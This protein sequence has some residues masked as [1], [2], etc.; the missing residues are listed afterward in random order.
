[1]GAAPPPPF[2]PGPPAVPPAGV[3]SVPP[4]PRRAGTAGLLAARP[5]GV[6]G[7]ARGLAPGPSGGFAAS[8]ACLPGATLQHFPP[9][10]PPPPPPLRLEGA[11]QGWREREG[12]PQLPPPPRC[13]GERRAGLGPLPQPACSSGHPPFLLLLRT[14]LPG[15]PPQAAPPP[16]VIAVLLLACS[17]D[18]WKPPRASS[19]GSAPTP[20]AAAGGPVA[21]PGSPVPRSRRAA[22]AAPAAGM[23]GAE[24]RAVGAGRG[25]CGRRR[26]LLPPPPPPS[27]SFPPPSPPPPPSPSLSDGPAC[28]DVK[29]S[30]GRTV[31]VLPR[32]RADVR[33]GARHKHVSAP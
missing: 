24:G 7:L 14:A 19:R 16:L 31:A 26:R 9:F 12:E 18:A 4:S 32:V 2:R 11:A 22:P 28:L 20:S 21:P 30:S 15:A 13:L 25:R 1:M 17:K 23:P 10:L 6:V 29:L 5:L 33:E 8:L 3:A 27:P